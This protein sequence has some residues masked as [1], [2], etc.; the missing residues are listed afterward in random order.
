MIKKLI[1]FTQDQVIW[2]TVY[3]KKTG[4]SVASIIRTAVE[5][6]MDRNSPRFKPQS[7]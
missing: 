1:S 5:E 6:Y 2:L 4:N 7:K 3:S